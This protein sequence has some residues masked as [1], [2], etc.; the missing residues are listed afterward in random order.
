MRTRKL[1]P[2]THTSPPPHT[3]ACPPNSCPTTAPF[4]APPPPS[5]P[6]RT[7]ASTLHWPA[8]RVARALLIA[9]EKPASLITTA[10]AG[11]WVG[12]W[13]R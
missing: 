13:D 12:G 2:P 5:L 1:P 10:G 6:M 11:G 8:K 9:T 3:H 7:L 4:P